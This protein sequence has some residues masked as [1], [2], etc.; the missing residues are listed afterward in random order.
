MLRVELQQNGNKQQ[1][2]GVGSFTEEMRAYSQDRNETTFRI[3]ENGSIRGRFRNEL[4]FEFV[5]EDMEFSSATPGVQIN[6]LDWFNIGG[7]QRAGGRRTRE[8]EIA[9]DF[10]FTLGKKHALRTGIEMESSWLRGDELTNDVGTFTFSTPDDFYAGRRV[11]SAARRRS[12]GRILEH[13]VRVVHQRRHP[14][15]Q[16]RDDE[17]RRALRS[18]VAFSS[19]Y[20]NFAPRAHVTWSPFKS[21]KTTFRAG[22]GVF[23]DW[24]DTALYEDTLRVN[25]V[26]QKDI[27]IDQPCYPDPFACG[28]QRARPIPA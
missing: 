10:D 23:Y 15:A 18:A 9:D 1:N 16:E 20:N 2:L 14:P 5:H 24:Y 7:A 17:P 3:S 8:I 13:R 28:Q 19:D 27:I 4:R 6:V 12:A 22:A 25:G 21:A 11:S 26:N